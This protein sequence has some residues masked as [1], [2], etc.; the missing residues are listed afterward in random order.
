MAARATAALAG[1][2][3][4]LWTD[5]VVAEC[6]YV[7]ESFYEVEPPRVAELMRSAIALPTIQTVDPATLLRALEVSIDRCKSITRRGTLTL[8]TARDAPRW[9]ASQCPTPSELPSRA[10]IP[11]VA[12]R[13]GR[14]ATELP[15]LA[16]LPRRGP[17]ARFNRR[18]FGV[19]SRCSASRRLRP[20]RS[21]FL[22]HHRSSLRC[23][24]P[25][26]SG[27]TPAGP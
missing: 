21:W 3:D 14:Q 5:L 9:P 18:G 2:G 15:L 17:L 1:E 13:S 22:G 25:V 7:L 12:W 8:T 6:V 10:T 19:R 20:R 26:C 4:L 16:G 24:R 27:R 11:I 23:R